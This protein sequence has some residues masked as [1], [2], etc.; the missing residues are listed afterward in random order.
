MDSSLREQAQR[1][2]L[3]Y[4]FQVYRMS[5]G[6]ERIFVSHHWH[7]E[8][9]VI[10]VLEGILSLTVN[11]EKLTGKPGD[12]FW[13]GQEELHGM[14]A[15]EDNTCYNALVFPMEL[16]SFELFDYTQSHYMNPLCRK[17]WTFPTKIPRQ[18][19]H[20]RAIWQELLE[21]AAAD[22]EHAPGYQIA[23]KAALFKF[24]SLL[25]QDELLYSAAEKDH[26]PSDFK[27]N[28]LKAI[29]TYI[30]QHYSEKMNLCDIARTFSLSPK[31]FSRYFK[32]NLDRNF[33]DYVNG[34]RVERAADLLLNTDIPVG[35]IALAVGF[36]NFSYFIRQFKKLR[37]C[38][39]SQYRKEAE[40]SVMFD[41]MTHFAAATEDAG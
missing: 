27:L 1:G 33:V 13:I 6:Q 36:D 28:T 14:S 18:S 24:V 10:F 31:Y 26:R 2:T 32:E 9:E 17:E 8:I 40:H 22:T 29:I 16:L 20:Y 7:R 21:I 41:H 5:G 38:T 12:I 3:L 30:Q 35:E 4:P 37:G 19:A 25:I 15:D 39:P 23:T 34:L 11:D